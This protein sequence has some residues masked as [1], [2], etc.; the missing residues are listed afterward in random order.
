RRALPEPDI[1]SFVS[2]EYEA[3][4]SELEC[5]LAV[6][7]SDI[8]KI[9]RVGR[10][11][12]FFM[13]GGHSLVAI[14]MIERL[15]QAGL[16]LSVRALFQTPTLSELAQ[17]LTKSQATTEAPKNLITCD[18]RRI[19]PELLPLID[20][21]QADIDAIVDRFNGEVSNIQDI[22][23]LSP[24]Q[25]GIL[26]HHIMAAKGD[27]YLVVTTMS[28]DN[29]SILDRY[30]G[31]MQKVVERHDILRTAIVW[32]GLSTPAQVVLRHAQLSVIKLS[33]NPINGPTVDQIM[34]IIDP[35]EH[36][37]DLTQAPLIRY[38]IAQNRDGTWIVIQLM[39]HIIGDHIAMKLN[40]N[41]ILLIMENQ[42]DMLSKPQPF[43]NLVAQVRSVSDT[44]F[45]DRFFSK[46]LAEI[47]TPTLP[48]G[49]SD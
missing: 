2:Q 47:D 11:D 34:K 33:L 43:R 17:S 32:E 40:M 21:T 12:N 46:M 18:T 28:F 9:D 41:E 20:L 19:T 3:P 22:Y 31:A 24:L 7:W 15:R 45:H 4:Q 35:R 27:P 48:Y 44:E 25:D 37:I 23:A 42:E 49:L 26:F 29:E 30:L 16:H 8:L 10:R 6:I 5:T 39:H 38:V 13:L 14:Q 1:S 36:R